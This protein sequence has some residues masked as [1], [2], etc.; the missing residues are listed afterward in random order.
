MNKQNLVPAS[1]FVNGSSRN[2]TIFKFK[3]W[4]QHHTSGVYLTESRGLFFLVLVSLNTIIQGFINIIHN[5]R[6][7]SPC[8][9]FKEKKFMRPCCVWS[10]CDVLDL[11]RYI[12]ALEP[13]LYM[14]LLYSGKE[15]TVEYSIN[16][17]CFDSYLLTI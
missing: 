1:L 10:L 12:P 15:R 6:E 13:T 5:I 7:S 2:H 11:V 14:H 3:S 4:S 17:V 16:A 8:S 9:V